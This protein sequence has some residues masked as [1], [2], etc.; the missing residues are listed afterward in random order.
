MTC[1]YAVFI[2]LILN[3]ISIVLPPWSPPLPTIDQVR[4]DQIDCMSDAEY[5]EYLK[6][7]AFFDMKDKD[8]M[9][10]EHHKRQR[11][12]LG[13]IQTQLQSNHFYPFW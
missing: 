13:R 5:L 9:M 1:Y 8:K 6:G 12:L 7:D 4:V 10:A 2:G 3:P 11:A